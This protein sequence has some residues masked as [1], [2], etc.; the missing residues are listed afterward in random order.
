MTSAAGTE[1]IDRRATTT[2]V[3]G[4]GPVPGYVSAKGYIPEGA[5]NQP[6][7]DKGNTQVGGTG[8][9][10]STYIAKPT[11]QKGA[12]IPGNAGRY[13]PD[14]SFNA[15][16]EYGYFGCMAASQASCVLG[17]DGAP[18][19]SFRFLAWGGTSASAPS[20][21]GV[22]AML[23][24][25]AGTAQGN[26][27]PTLYSLARTPSNG[28]FHDITVAS[29]GVT[30]CSVN[31]ASLCNNSLPSPTSLTG[32]L[33]GYLVGDGYDPVTGLGS[34][35]VSRLLESWVSAPTGPIGHST[36]RMPPALLGRPLPGSRAQ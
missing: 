23:N 26:L 12:G 2:T 5:W 17:A 29:S 9:G 27:N 14:V 10:V 32:G 6:L 30:D 1:T 3:L 8:G 20:M 21:A 15:S 24:Q 28:V 4:R 13:V 11:W 7:D 34:I 18:T 19:G 25:K 36:H 16:T 31:T 33:A 22:A 35:D